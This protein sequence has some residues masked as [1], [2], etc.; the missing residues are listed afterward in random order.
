MN[1]LEQH[2]KRNDRMRIAKRLRKD[3]LFEMAEVEV[4]DYILKNFEW[5][6]DWELIW[7]LLAVVGRHGSSYSER[8]LMPL[9]T[10]NADQEFSVYTGLGYAHGRLSIR[11]ET[12]SE[13]VPKF[14]SA[15]SNGQTGFADGLFVGVLLA[16]YVPSE[17]DQRAFLQTMQSVPLEISGTIFWFYACTYN[18]TVPE[19]DQFILSVRPKIRQDFVE[20]IDLSLAGTKPK[21]RPLFH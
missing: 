6:D 5:D 16:E 17:Q 9:I 2:K 11:N 15:I 20:A 10:A 13:R 18:W 19:K 4:V 1:L 12:F 14:C 8:M 3:G 21:W 7:L